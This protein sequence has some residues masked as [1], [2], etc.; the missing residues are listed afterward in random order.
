MSPPTSRFFKKYILQPQ[1]PWYEHFTI[2]ENYSYDQGHIFSI[3]M[4][5][6]CKLCLAVAYIGIVHGEATWKIIAKELQVYM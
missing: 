5:L 3:T 1:N 6:R 2:R 4:A